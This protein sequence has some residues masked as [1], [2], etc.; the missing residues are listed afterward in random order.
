MTQIPGDI[1]LVQV[2]DYEI[3]TLKFKSLNSEKNLIFGENKDTIF[4]S[5]FLFLISCKL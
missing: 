5:F 2:L 1:C 3:K 4:R